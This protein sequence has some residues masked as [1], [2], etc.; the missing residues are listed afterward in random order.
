MTHIILLIYI[1]LNIINKMQTPKHDQLLLLLF[2]LFILN[3]NEIE[4]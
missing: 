4:K 1:P 3:E 2:H